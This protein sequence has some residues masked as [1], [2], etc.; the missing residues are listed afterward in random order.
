ME[1]RKNPS[2]LLA[3][4]HWQGGHMGFDFQRAANYLNVHVVNTFFSHGTATM[5]HLS[6]SGAIF[7]SPLAVHRL[8]FEDT[9]RV[10]CRE[11][12]EKS[13]GYNF[14]FQTFLNNTAGLYGGALNVQCDN[15]YFITATCSVDIRRSTFRNNHAP[16][17]G[18]CPSVRPSTKHTHFDCS[19]V[20]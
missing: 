11:Q 17:A 3:F 18:L 10:E 6:A 2:P 7:V 14:L 19:Q 8:V 1:Q 16:V 15:V 5:D 9:V 20:C 4:N 13:F 12:K